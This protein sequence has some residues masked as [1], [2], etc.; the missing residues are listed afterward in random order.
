MQLCQTA[1]R[2]NRGLFVWHYIT[3]IVLTCR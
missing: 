1:T 2:P 3:C